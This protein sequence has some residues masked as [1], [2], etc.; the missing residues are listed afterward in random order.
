MA[1]TAP[2]HRHCIGDRQGAFVQDVAVGSPV[3]RIDA[4]LGDEAIHIFETF[5]VARIDYIAAILVDD[6]RGAFVLVA[7]ERGALLR[8][9][10]GSKRV[11]LDDPPEAIG[12]VRLL[13]DVETLV[14]LAPGVIGSAAMP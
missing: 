13:G 9:R 5:V 3:R 6:A 1:A 12:F 4:S 2:I 11:D 8:H 14:E 10:G 7:A